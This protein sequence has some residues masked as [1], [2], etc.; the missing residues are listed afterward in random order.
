LFEQWPFQPVRLIG[1]TAERLSQGRGQLDLF[2]DPRRDRQR[3]LDDAADQI[4]RRFG[5]RAI[6]RAGPG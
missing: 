6:R 4:N 1:V 5:K 3:K 2:A